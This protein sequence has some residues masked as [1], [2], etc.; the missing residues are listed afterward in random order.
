MFRIEHQPSGDEAEADN[1]DAAILAA[2]TLI[3]DN[4]DTGTCRV[5]YGGGVVAVVW[6]GEGDESCRIWSA[7]SLN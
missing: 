1:R 6:P 7:A 5:F 3:A 2:K 4:D